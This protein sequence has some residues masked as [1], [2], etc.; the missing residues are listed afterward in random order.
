MDAQ[1]PHP[2]R[3]ARI[4]PGVASLRRRGGKAAPGTSAGGPEPARKPEAVVRYDITD[5]DFKALMS[6]RKARFGLKDSVDMIVE[7]GETV[8]QWTS[9]ADLR[10]WLPGAHETRD[11]LPVPSDT[12]PGEYALDVGILDEAGDEAHVQLAIE[13]ARDDGW[14]PISTVVVTD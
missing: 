5:E 14:Y 8:A 2:R 4:L 3:A 12:V 1:G 9:T 7:S 10:S 11:L 13:G 6:R